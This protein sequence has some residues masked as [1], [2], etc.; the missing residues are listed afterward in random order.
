[1]DAILVRDEATEIVVSDEHP[2]SSRGIPAVLANSSPIGPGDL[3]TVGNEVVQAGQFVHGYLC[4]FAPA[5][6]QPGLLASV[7][8]WLRQDPTMAAQAAYLAA[9]AD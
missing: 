7:A 5:E 2:A 6:P 8:R 1:M 4:L 9:G 3:L